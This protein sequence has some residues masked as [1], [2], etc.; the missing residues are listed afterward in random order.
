MSDLDDEE[1]KATR[2][3][4][5][6]DKKIANEM[7]YELGYI[8]KFK[9]HCEDE[10]YRKDSSH[11]AGKSIKFYNCSESIEIYPCKIN[12]QELKAINKK[13]EELGWI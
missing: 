5:G 10:M 11:Q 6:A 12:T 4:N 8:E 7:F 13:C 9:N 3:L 1:L 2:I